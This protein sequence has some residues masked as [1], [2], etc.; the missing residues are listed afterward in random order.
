MLLYVYCKEKMIRHADRVVYLH[1]CVTPN[2]KM[3]VDQKFVFKGSMYK[4]KIHNFIV[5]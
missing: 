4:P 2:N 3:H 5:D 1:V